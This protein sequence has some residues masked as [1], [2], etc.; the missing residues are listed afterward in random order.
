MNA[1]ASIYIIIHVLISL[2]GIFT[3]FIIMFG[4]LSANRMNT[5]TAVF[6]ASTV[7]T[8]LSGFPLPAQLFMPSHAVGILSLIVL[9]LVI[10]ARYPKRMAGGWRRTYVITAMLAFYLN[11]FVLVVQLFDKV[12]DLK[13]LA[14]TQS[15][16]PFAIAQGT[17][18][19][20]FVVM[21]VLAAKNFR[22]SE[23]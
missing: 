17:V 14:P 3:G 16:P 4:L 6:L 7:L 9:A 10:F 20:V 19:V 1:D 11:C 12:P 22:A 13:A 21:T 2:V 18:L 8:S 23:I 15:E 5:W